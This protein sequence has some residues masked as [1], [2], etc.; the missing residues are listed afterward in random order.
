MTILITLII[1]VIIGIASTVGGWYSGFWDK[2]FMGTLNAILGAIIGILV[3][4]LISLA[5]PMQLYEKHYSYEL[6]S[7]Q[8]GN[9]VHG[10]FFLGC[11]TI[12]GKMQYVWYWGE[13]GIYEMKQIEAKLV[14][15]KYTEGT[16]KVNITEISATDSWVNDWALDLDLHDKTYLIEVPKG[17]IKQ[18]Y[19]L[20]AQ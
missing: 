13:N 7:L 2:F 12:D 10:S 5:L 8:D 17:T 14:R 11:G 3:G 4:F 20:D 18:N 19:S 6:E 9:T 16:A 1:G 15:I